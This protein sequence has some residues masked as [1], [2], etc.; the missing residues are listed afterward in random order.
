MQPML[1]DDRR[2]GA[3]LPLA[4]GMIKAVDRAREIGADAMQIFTDNPTAWKHRAAPPRE[5]AVFR[6][7]LRAFDI[8]PISIHASYLVNLA[9]SN[10]PSV[11]RSIE[12][13]AHELRHAPAFGA[14]FVNVHIGSHLG[15]GVAVGIE[16]LADGIRRALQAADA[17]LDASQAATPSDA[18]TDVD[19][20]AA[21]GERAMLVL[22]NSAGSGG[23]LGTSVAELAAIAVAIDARGVPSDRV[24]FCIDTA[25]AWGAGI[26]V[27]TPSAVDDLVS[28][29]DME[30]GL[31][32]LVMIHLND[33]RSD[34]G[35]RTDRHEHL[36]GGSIGPAG[37][38][39]VLCHPDLAHA[40]YVLETPG[41]DE[42]YDAINLERA[43][44][45]AA[46]RP[47]PPL[48]AGAFQLRGSAR[49]RTAPA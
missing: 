26:D 5:L 13:L 18:D 49:A 2:L 6:E 14:R 16:R 17:P 38:A 22:E 37:L 24:G 1:P 48:P 30:I 31:R 43:R 4:S 25:H 7:R 28:E 40:A 29:F 34:R 32:R 3:H 23:G 47:L 21:A 33:S 46:G 44:L 41:M 42:G 20:D 12:M 9:G 19:A 10:A 39:R 15:L 45:L 11:E 36:G 8:A 35:S 27:A